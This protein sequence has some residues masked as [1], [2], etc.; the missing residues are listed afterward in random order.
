MKRF[1]AIILCCLAVFSANA[2]VPKKYGKGAVPIVNGRV[3]F[4]RTIHTLDGY[5]ASQIFDQAKQ[6]SEKRFAKPTVLKA[7]I[8][9][10]D[11]IAKR[12]VLNAEEYIT[13][14]N[15]FLV[16][17]R[18]RINYWLE[19]TAVDNGFTL[20]MTRINYWYEEERDGGQRFTAEQYITDEE[21]YNAKQTKFLRGFGKFRIKTIDLVDQLTKEFSDRF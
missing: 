10:M 2:Q 6:W 1:I 16:L 8:V 17:D 12:I 20:K 14:R 7:S 11:P 4:E 13:F 18:T 5:S 3:T 21:C 19:I 9:E 15:T